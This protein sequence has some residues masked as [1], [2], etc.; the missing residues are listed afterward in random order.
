MRIAVTGASGFVGSHV[1]ADL[2]RRGVRAVAA[3]RARS[4]QAAGG[5]HRGVAIDVHAPGP[6]PFATLGHPDVLIHLAWGSL[7]DYGSEVH[8]VAEL[9]AHVRFL[10]DLVNSGLSGIVVAGTCMEYGMRE[11]EL[12]ENDAAEPANPYAAAKNALR[13]ALE[14]M[15]TRVPFNLTWARIFYLYGPGQARTSLFSQLSAAHAS[16]APTLDM[17]SGDQLRDFLPVELAASTLVDLA[18]QGRG[19]GVVNVCSGRPIAV[20]EIAEL[21]IRENHWNVRLILGARPDS[22]FEPRAFWGNR[23]KL[24]GLLGDRTA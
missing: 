7:P 15:R 18:V 1:L 20:R 21:W 24:D 17:S 13:L 11:G 5:Y 4:D 14:S 3:S 10:T 6:D 22:P 16:G 23:S 2:K 9:P 19:H 12:T 8:T